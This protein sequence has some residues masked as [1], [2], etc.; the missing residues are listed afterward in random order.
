M[1]AKGREPSS[2]PPTFPFALSLDLETRHFFVLGSI[3]GGKTQVI[4]P[5]MLAAQASNDLS[6]S[7]Q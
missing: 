4:L 7:I 5:L 2:T 1:A 3:G 6:I